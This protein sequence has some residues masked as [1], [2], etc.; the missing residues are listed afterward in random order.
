M[1]TLYTVYLCC[2]LYM[3][4]YLCSQRNCS[5]P[6]G[7][8]WYKCYCDCANSHQDCWLPSRIS[9][10]QSHSNK[11][12]PLH[13]HS[14]VRHLFIV[15]LPCVCSVQIHCGNISVLTQN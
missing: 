3:Y 7:D 8:V 1:H 15:L 9:P 5:F 4:V 11:V 10:L 14:I 13:I 2:V 12:C 6:A